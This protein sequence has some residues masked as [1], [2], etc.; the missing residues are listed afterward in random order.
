MLKN[1]LVIS[2]ASVAIAA[3]VVL[4]G[5]ASSNADQG[6]CANAA[7]ANG[8]AHA[9]SKSAHGDAKQSERVCVPP[10]PA[11]TP[12]PTPTPPPALPPADL[13]VMA[14]FVNMPSTATAGAQFQLSASVNVRNN[15]TASTVMADTAFTPAVP[16]DC[17]ATPGAVV[18]QDR[19]FPL[20]TS[21][22]ISRFW[23]VTCTAPGPHT[24]SMGLNVAIDP[25]Q[26]F[27]DPNP[28]NNNGS[29]GGST[30]V[31]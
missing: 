11:P 19:W 18:V 16:A 28:A 4:F 5:A 2:V 20:N 26:A 9:N 14:V 1:A 30:Q 6:G 7:A 12:E 10:T 31:N 22:F 8:A 27:S 15:G 23:F 21:V 29:G 25:T 17:A 13:Q 24:F 3:V